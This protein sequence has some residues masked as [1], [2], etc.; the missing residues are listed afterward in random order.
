MWDNKTKA[1]CAFLVEHKGRDEWVA[2]R[3]VECIELLGHVK[4]ILKTDG[5]KAIVALVDAVKVCT[6]LVEYSYAKAPVAK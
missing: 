1:C 4:I 5:E 6:G 2:R 3:V